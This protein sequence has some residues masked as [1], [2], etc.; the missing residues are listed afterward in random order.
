LPLIHGHKKID[1]SKPL[2]FGDFGDFEWTMSK[3]RQKRQKKVLVTYMAEVKLGMQK[4]L[5]LEGE[6]LLLPLPW[7]WKKLVSESIGLMGP[8]TDTPKIGTRSPGFGRLCKSRSAR[9]IRKSSILEGMNQWF[10]AVFPIVSVGNFFYLR[11]VHKDE[12][13]TIWPLS[14]YPHAQAQLPQ[15]LRSWDYE[16][17]NNFNVW[18]KKEHLLFNVIWWWET[19]RI[20]QG[21]TSVWELSTDTIIQ[22]SDDVWQS[23]R[24][25][26]KSMLFFVI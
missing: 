14:V 25:Y 20:L 6:C 7:I 2:D 21:Q 11:H 9:E 18:A 1:D 12:H 13:V 19:P 22:V 8:N 3:F 17:N 5:D 24:S 15:N 16:A 26:C 23:S 10:V 4:F